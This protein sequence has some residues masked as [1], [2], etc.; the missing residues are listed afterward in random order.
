MPE[1]WLNYGST[2]T[3][4]DIRAE[5]LGDSIGAAGSALT[6]EGLGER[7]EALEAVMPPRIVMLN[8][9]RAT[10]KAIGALR[11]LCESKSTPFPSILAERA[12]VA[13]ARAVLPEGIN[14]AEFDPA[15]GPGGGIAFLA[16]A[17]L[18]GLF[19]YETVATRLLRRFG[20]EA[21]H[22]AYTKRAGN[23]PVPGQETPCMEE[24]KSFAAGLDVTAIEVIGG[25]DGIG[26]IATGNPAETAGAAAPLGKT[27]ALES[28]NRSMILSTG[29]A[30]SGATLSRALHSLWSCARAVPGGGLVVLLAECSGGLGSEALRRFVEGR[31]TI[32]RTKRPPT[33]MEG[34][35][36]LL[37]LAEARERM[38]VALVSTIPDLYTRKLW[39]SS[40]D[41]TKLA[42]E[43]ILKKGPRQ[44]VA[45]IADG[46][47]TLL[48]A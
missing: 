40:I 5:N 8:A 11:E 43:H 12:L 20:G 47:H 18:D 6:A 41:S 10:A 13:Q 25:G 24:A 9:T 26:E 39:M 32:E 34:M 2:D 33:Y 45:V 29:N 16:E 22:K 37:Y 21:M 48:G 42:L 1:I 28:S 15:G 44:K 30:H 4:L 31:M 23:S 7:L 36:D 38:A 19:G 3:V 27:R 14:V 35:E 17:E 46:A